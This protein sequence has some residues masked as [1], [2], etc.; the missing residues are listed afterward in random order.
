MKTLLFL[1]V[2]V[3]LTASAQTVSSQ[4]PTP[5]ININTISNLPEMKIGPNDLLQIAVYESPELSGTVRVNSDGFIRLPMVHEGIHAGNLYPRELELRIQDALADE[6][7]VVGP[8]VTVTVAEYQSRTVSVVGE[9]HHPLTFQAIGNVTLLDAIA[10]AE[11]ISDTAGDEV[12]VRDGNDR[13]AVAVR[14]IPVKGL[15]SGKSPELNLP[16]HGG[17][18]IRIPQQG[19][20]SVVGNVRR[21]GLFPISRDEQPTVLNAIAQTQG[22]TQYASKRAYI[23]RTVDTQKTKQEIPVELAKI[24]DR[25]DPDVALQ[26]GD[27]LY[28]PD[29]HGRRNTLGLMDKLIGVGSVASSAV[30]YAGER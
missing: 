28:I 7:L 2:P 13:A 24:M 9:V 20:L 16:L 3:C 18:E 27:I 25:K 23:Y 15:M 21:P 10:K 11:G 26:A 22:L 8:V 19:H 14:R 30:V 29:D 5:Q 17:E 12:L 6:K 1:L 4:P